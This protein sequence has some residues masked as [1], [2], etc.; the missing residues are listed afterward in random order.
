G[1]RRSVCFALPG[2]PRQAHRCPGE[3]AQREGQHWLLPQLRSDSPVAFGHL[4]R[5][6]Y[7]QRG[8]GPAPA[9]RRQLPQG[10]WFLVEGRPRRT[11]GLRQACRTA[12]T[13]GE[14]P[15]RPPDTSLLC[16]C[17][18]SRVGPGPGVL[19]LAAAVEAVPAW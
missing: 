2:R 18:S 6:L 19:L 15:G 4:R 7:A 11:T 16:G 9:H 12:P 10:D 5:Q 8:E 14:T 3:P 1:A 13:R 17:V